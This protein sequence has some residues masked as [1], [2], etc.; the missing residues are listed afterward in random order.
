MLVSDHCLSS[1]TC[2]F[3][4]EDFPITEVVQVW[5]YS[6][7]IAWTVEIGTDWFMVQHREIGIEEWNNATQISGN[8][9]L[10]VFLGLQNQTEYEYRVIMQRSEDGS[11]AGSDVGSI[12]TC[13]VGFGSPNCSVG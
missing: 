12:T 8:Q 13:A 9:Y 5:S 7:T 3:V 1:F 10:Y 4:S 6:F 2:H 11:V